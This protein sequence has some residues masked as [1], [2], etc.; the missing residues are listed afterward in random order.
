M[1]KLQVCSDC[2]NVH[3]PERDICTSCWSEN[4]LWSEVSAHGTITSVTDLH[5]S[6][7]PQWKDKLPLRLG[8]V[9]LDAG[10]N[11]LAFLDSDLCINDKI[12][13]CMDNGIYSATLKSE[14]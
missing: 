7:K 9:A 14:N 6:A 1:I 4:L 12:V 3:Y 8:L 2:Q 11:I 10:V 5:I 13:L